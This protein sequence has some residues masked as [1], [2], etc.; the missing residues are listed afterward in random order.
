MKFLRHPPPFFFIFLDFEKGFRTNFTE[1]EG[2]QK[3]ESQDFVTPLILSGYCDSNA[4]PPAPKA[5][6]LTN[7]A[8]SRLAFG[9][10]PKRMQRYLYFFNLQIFFEKF[11]RTGN[12]L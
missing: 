4:G 7:C 3:K 5:G 1:K 6:A 11:S 12:F 9:F 10:V 8:T 2:I